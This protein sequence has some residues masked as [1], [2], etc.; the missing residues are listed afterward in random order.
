MSLPIKFIVAVCAVFSLFGCTPSAPDGT[1]I[2]SNEQA[3][4]AMQ[5]IQELTQTSFDKLQNRVALDPEEIKN[6]GLAEPIAQNLVN[7]DP[8]DIGYKSIL[9]KIQLGLEKN[10]PALASLNNALLLKPKPNDEQDPII[11]AGIHADISQIYFNKGEL[12]SALKS[13]KSASEILPGDPYFLTN[14]ASILVELERYGE[15]KKLCQEALKIDAGH[16]PALD[17]LKLLDFPT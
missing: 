2:S 11:R 8:L 7:F 14:Q 1:Q 12:E 15:A 3:V 4:S 6:L 16:K 9:G 10:D 13:I 5:K 17:L